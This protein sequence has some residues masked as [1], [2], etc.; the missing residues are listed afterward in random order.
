[1]NREQ[2]IKALRGRLA[3]IDAILDSNDDENDKSKAAIYVKN[4]YAWY[5]VKSILDA[6]VDDRHAE[7]YYQLWGAEK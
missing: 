2:L 4:L 5:E 7:L 1:M 6:L 3:A